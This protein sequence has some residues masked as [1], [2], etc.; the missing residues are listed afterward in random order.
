MRR[1]TLVRLAAM[2]GVAAGSA[3]ATGRAFAPAPDPGRRSYAIACARCHGGD[4]KGG[5]Q[6][7]D[8]VKR[9]PA[10]DDESLAA[11]IRDGLPAAGMPGSSMAE[12]DRR[13]LVAYLRALRDERDP[14]ARVTLQTT[15]G[16]TLSGRPTSPMSSDVQLL[17]DD[18]AVHLLRQA[19]ERY[20]RVTSEAEWPTYHGSLAGN[21]YSA[22]GQI[23][24][25]NVAHLAPRWTYSL[26]GTP[27]LEVTPV[28]V[29]GIMYV[30]AVNEC[31]ALDAGNGRRIWEYRRPRSKGLAGDAASGINRGVAVA[32][33]RVFLVTDNA[34]LI[35]LDRFTGALLW[36][37]EMADARENYGATSAPLAV[38]GLVISGPSGGDEGVRGFLAAFDQATGKE[39][40]RFWT[41]PRRG[42]PGSETWKG[43][44]IDHPCATAWL[45]GTYD[46]VLDTLYWP[47]GNPCADYDGRERLGDNL[48]SDSILA[49][50]PAT[51]RL[52]WYFQ[53]TPHDVW[54]WDAEQPPVLVDADWQGRPRPL[55]LHANRNGFFYVL[56]RASGALLRA[57]PFVKKLTW[58]SAIGPDGR[59]VLRP[60]QEPTPDGRTVCPSVEGATNWFSTSFHPALGLYYVQA[61]EKCTLYTRGEGEWEAGRSYYRGTTQQAPGEPARKVLRAIDVHTGAVAWERPQ[62]GAGHSWGGT[63]ATAS[64]LVFF[65]ED[66]GAFMAV[67]AATGTPRWQFPANATWK[68]S[69]M[70]YSFDGRQYV[71]VAAGPT[72][73]AFGL[74][75]AEGCCAPAPLR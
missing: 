29:D 45:T 34:H 7:P 44:D 37:T 19:G 53:Y 8:I 24:A 40:W 38:R 25:T 9:L 68:A 22:L 14:P 64:G 33:G 35:A 1:P 60:D 18:G 52:K 48:Y 20:R 66:G 50:D 4:G 32:G 6:G 55:L 13:D 23:D 5:E 15:D 11:L 73:L 51:G 74:P 2:A 54:D 69:P 12:P 41:V 72:I 61:L 27:R 39:A 75:D 17:S 65:G 31:H 21:R 42:E 71:A 28:V 67:D 47:T 30:T 63:L 70:T 58:A 3:A 16:R 26:G 57:T 62:A 36:D 43:R 46:A 10:R 59:P 49:L 56:D